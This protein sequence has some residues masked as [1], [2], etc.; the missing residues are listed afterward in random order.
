[1]AA[2][3]LDLDEQEAGVL[4]EVLESAHSELGYE[5]ANT[6]SKDYREK[7]KQRQALIQRVVGQLGGG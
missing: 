2:I 1:M 3:E 4:R 5:I 7:L 6:D